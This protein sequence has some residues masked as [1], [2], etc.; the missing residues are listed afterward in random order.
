[1][2]V[3]KDHDGDDVGMVFHLS[4]T[5]P[6][7]KNKTLNLTNL[8]LK[9]CGGGYGTAIIN[10]EN[11]PRTFVPALAP[12]HTHTHIHSHAPIH[13]HMHPFNRTK[14]RIYVF[15]I[16]DLLLR[17]GISCRVGCGDMYGW[18]CVCV[19]VCMCVCVYGCMGVRVYGCMGDGDMV[20]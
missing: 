1:M 16:F 8:N 2:N 15:Q 7:Y 5:S 14:W 19:Y 9:A 3:N 12:L 10:A 18:R 13:S 4:I 17:C 6:L 11:R 20:T